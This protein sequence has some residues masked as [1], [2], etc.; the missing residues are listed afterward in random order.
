MSALDAPAKLIVTLTL[1]EMAEVMHQY[2]KNKFA[3]HEIQAICIVSYNTPVM[4]IEPGTAG[5]VET[6]AC[7]HR[8]NGN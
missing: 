3:P 2:C 1:T 8:A 4:Q 5:L 7:R 6:F